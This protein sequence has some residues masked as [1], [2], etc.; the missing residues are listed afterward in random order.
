MEETSEE[1]PNF[2]IGIDFLDPDP[3]RSKNKAK[4]SC[5]FLK[6]V[7]RLAAANFG[8]KTF[9]GNKNSHQHLKII[10][11]F[12]C[13][14][15]FFIFFFCNGAR[16][17]TSND[18]VINLLLFAD[19]WQKINND[20]VCFGARYDQYG[21]LSVTKTGFAKAIKLVHRKASIKC[22]PNHPST[23]WS[24]GNKD[25]HAKN[26]FMTIIINA[27]R[28]ALLPSVVNLYGTEGCKTGKNFYIF[29]TELVKDH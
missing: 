2:S 1:L 6:F 8:R 18:I 7:E 5:A 22:H 16:R 26:T 4:T 27:K 12:V 19:V 29:L 24:C 21:A 11:L 9:T 10:V 20:T 28:E 25:V 15:F 23:C 14:L 3:T 13:L 17:L